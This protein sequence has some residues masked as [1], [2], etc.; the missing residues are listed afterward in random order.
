[1]GLGYF[2]ISRAPSLGWACAAIIFAHLGGSSVWV[3][4]TTLLQLN[5]EDAYRGRVFSAELG[6]CMLSIATCAAIAG[7]ALDHAVPAR[8]VAAATGIAMLIP[9]I[10]WALFAREQ[11][12]THSDLT[13]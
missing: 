11:N 10:A 6:L 3:F 2:A 12:V 4:S 13:H 1:M 8:T 7:I 5:T 9:T